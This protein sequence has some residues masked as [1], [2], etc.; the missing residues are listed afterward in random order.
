MLSKF[1]IEVC[2]TI[3]N[4]K[5]NNLNSAC[6]VS[7]IVIAV[8]G[9]IAVF[10]LCPMSADSV[11]AETLFKERI[12]EA[13]CQ[14]EKKI[15]SGLD[16]GNDSKTLSN[17][18]EID[19]FLSSLLDSKYTIPSILGIHQDHHTHDYFLTLDCRH[20]NEYEH[21]VELKIPLIYLCTHM[22]KTFERLVSRSTFCF[23]ADASAGLGPV[24]LSEMLE[25][26]NEQ[27][28]LTPKWLCIMALLIESKVFSQPEADKILFALCRLEA[29]RFQAYRTIV[30]NLPGQAFVP[31]LLPALVRIF[32]CE[33]H[34]FMY[35]GCCSTVHRSLTAENVH[36]SDFNQSFELSRATVGTSMEISLRD[37]KSKLSQL[38][39]NMSNAVYSWM[40]SVDTFLKL[41]DDE[42]KNEY[43][44]FVLRLSFLVGRINGI[45][46]GKTDLSELCMSNLLQFVTGSRSRPLESAILNSARD[47]IQRAKVD[48]LSVSRESILSSSQREAIEA[49]VFCHKGILLEGKTLVDTVKPKTEWSLKAKKKLQSCACCDLP[50]DDDNPGP[51]GFKIRWKNSTGFVDGNVMCTVV[52]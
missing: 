32:P 28:V 18:E 17:E 34:V 35:D 52:K 51:D 4:N 31:A 41:K 16:E 25:M 26:S 20:H 39:K 50:E 43:L 44:P 46:N 12:K 38:P 9:L 30:I 47:V 15:L 11:N 48:D 37:Y 10:P 23:I 33:R 1:A 7:D 5:V 3:V 14:L 24:L 21:M 40:S 29:L 13:R 6:K 42:D 49:C 22:A 36:G 27:I 19:K 45:G 2:I 8:V